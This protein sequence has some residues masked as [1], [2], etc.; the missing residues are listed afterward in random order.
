MPP[1]SPWERSF[2]TPGEVLPPWGTLVLKDAA[3]GWM[4]FAIVWGAI[5]LVGSNVAQSAS[6]HHDDHNAAVVQKADATAASGVV[7]T[8][9]ASTPF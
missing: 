2:A 5:L 3:R 9:P 8:G 7:H 1:P 6:R 4:I